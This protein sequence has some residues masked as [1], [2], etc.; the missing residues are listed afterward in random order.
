MIY[1]HHH[2][3][4]TSVDAHKNFWV[5]TLGAGLTK[6]GTVPASVIKFPNVLIFLN[7]RAP[8]G[9]TKGTTVNHLGFQVPNLRAA[10]D[11]T[12]AAGYPVVTRAEVSERYEVADD[13]AFITELG[14]SVAFVM[15][16]DETKVEYLEN[17]AMTGPMSFHHIHYAAPDAA[18]MRDWYV[19]VF[20]ATA[21]NRGPFISAVL[22][23]V[24][25]SFS[26]AAAPVVGTRGR[27]LDRVGFEI[28][29]LQQFCRDLEAKGI[30]LD[31]GYARIPA[32]DIAVASLIDPWGTCIEL[33]EGLNRMQP[34][35]MA[36]SLR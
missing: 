18:A 11:K 31:R 33:I 6:V 27:A 4:V 10:I 29:N 13:V 9:G 24:S 25:L 28:E 1:G 14:I 22:P 2:L 17:P 34:P 8:S 7:Q 12:K 20:G 35:A 21:A 3:N 32:T 26:P 15:G 5:T 30:A 36:S 16:P 23:G 19:K